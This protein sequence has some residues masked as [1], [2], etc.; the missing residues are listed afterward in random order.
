MTKSICVV[1]VY[2]LTYVRFWTFLTG[3]YIIDIVNKTSCDKGGACAKEMRKRC[4]RILSDNTYVKSTLKF[5]IFMTL[6]IYYL[7]YK[8]FNFSRV[9]I[10]LALVIRIGIK[11]HNI[12]HV[13][14]HCLQCLLPEYLL[15]VTSAPAAHVYQRQY[16]DIHFHWDAVQWNVANPNS[17]KPPKS[18]LHVSVPTSKCTE[19]V[20]S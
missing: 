14:L 16:L 5:G 2:F 3:R 8:L 12:V 4:N 19:T 1:L 15:V 20:A 18:P 17:L 6:Q 10:L 13:T 9:S 7:C 11:Q